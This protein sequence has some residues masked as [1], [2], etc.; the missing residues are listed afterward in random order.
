VEPETFQ[1]ALFN[2]LDNALR[3]AEPNSVIRVHGDGHQ[4]RV[5]NRGPAI[6]GYALSRVTERFYSLAAPGQEKS[7]GLGLAM[8]QEIGQLHGGELIVEKTDAGVAV[9]LILAP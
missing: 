4:L 7:S 6:P 9:T 1:L 8:V 3:F 2:L 5:E